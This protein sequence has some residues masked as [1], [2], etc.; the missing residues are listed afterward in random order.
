MSPI[1]AE[2]LRIAY[3]R[4]VVL[5]PGYGLALAQAQHQAREIADL[6]EKRGATHDL[7]FT[8]WLGA[9]QGT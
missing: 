2:A 7:S 6:I 3:A 9:C 1:S 4:K 8:Q 5:V